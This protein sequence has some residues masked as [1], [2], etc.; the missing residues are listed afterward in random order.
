VTPRIKPN[1]VQE[2]LL[3]CITFP[4]PLLVNSVQTLHG[5]YYCYTKCHAV[6]SV[7]TSHLSVYMCV[8]TRGMEV[9]GSFLNIPLSWL[10]VG[11]RKLCTLVAVR[12][13]LNWVR[14]T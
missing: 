1:A 3:G 11:I 8:R 13:R 10:R 2:N 5:M 9:W 14:M 6:P 12:G 7:L 4:M